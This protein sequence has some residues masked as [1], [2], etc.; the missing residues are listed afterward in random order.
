[1]KPRHILLLLFLAFT[2]TSAQELPETF[3]LR[4]VNGQNYVS[5]VKAQSGGTCW[6][7]GTMASVESNLMVTGVWLD[8]GESGEP[9]LAEYHLDWWNG[10]NKFYN[11]DII[12]P[13]STELQVHQGGDYLVSTAYFSRGDGAVRDIDGQSYY[14][15]PEFASDSYH[16]YYIRDVEWYDIGENLERIILLKRKIMEYGAVATVILAGITAS[17]Y[18][19]YQPPED[20]RPP[21]HSVTIIGW[22]DK[23][24]T[25]APLPGAWLVKNS[26]GS[27][28][29]EDGYFWISYYDKHVGHYPEMGA[30]SF[31]NVEPMQ[32]DHVYFH[33]YHGWRNTKTD[34]EAVVNAFDAVASVGGSESMEAVSFYTAADNVDYT[35]KIYGGVSEGELTDE[36][37]SQIGFIEFT[38]FHT[39]DLT[40]P[41]ELKEGDRFY[42]YLQLSDGGYA[43]DQTS[44]VPL[45]LS[46]KYNNLVRSKASRGE[47]FYREGGEWLDLIDLDTTANFCIKALSKLDYD[48]DGIN[49]ILDNCPEE[50][51]PGQADRDGDFIGDLCDEC[52]DDPFNDIDGDGICGDGDNCPEY[53]NP[54]Q[55]DND[56]DGIGDDCDNCPSLY[57]PGQEDSDGD[58]DGDA[59][60]LCPNDPLNDIDADGFCGDVDNC[61]DEYNPEQSDVN[62]N[63]IGD[64]CEPH[65]VVYTDP[66]ANMNDVKK[67]SQFL[68][69]FDNVID[70]D[71]LMNTTASIA[72][73]SSGLHGGLRQFDMGQREIFIEPD[74][75]FNAGE[76]VEV[77]IATDLGVIRSSYSY[78]FRIACALSSGRFD[79]PYD[80]YKVGDGPLGID[81]GDFNGDGL[82]DLATAN[83]YDDNITVYFN[84]GAGGFA[85]KADYPTGNGAIDV[86]AF[87]LDNDFDLD[88]V[89]ANQ[90]ANNVTVL[91]NDGSGIFTNT[92]D[93]TVKNMPTGVFVSDVDGD[94]FAD[95]LTADISSDLGYVTVL[96]ND[97]AGQFGERSDFLL[98]SKSAGV[99]TGD[100]DN[101]GDFDMASADLNSNS[102]SVFKNNRRG[103]FSARNNYPA[104]N[105]PY[106][107]SCGDIDRDFDLDLVATNQIGNTVTVLFNDG[108]AGFDSAATYNTPQS[109]SGVELG[110]IDGDND[111]DIVTVNR[112]AGSVSIFYNNGEGLF[113]ISSDYDIGG[114]PYALAIADFNGD[115]ILDIAA[116]DRDNSNI[117]IL[118]QRVS[119][120]LAE[121]EDILPTE[122]KLDQNYPNPFNPE[123]EINFALPRSEQTSLEIYNILGQKVITLIDEHLP[124]GIHSVRW[125][126]LDLNGNPVSSGVY[127]YRFE[128]GEFNG[129]RKMILLK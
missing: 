99:V 6:T 107:I 31:H 51:N 125:N 20:E 105:Y 28:W 2:V 34:C 69:A 1:M 33:D 56:G 95:I 47:S 39:I 102:I 4:N 94:G 65:H 23:K 113:G 80:Q 119:T 84:D 38:G 67:D 68:F 86:M 122:Y 85:G 100:F 3:D 78:Q 13:D 17:D 124:A 54:F 91:R 53:A 76:L 81:A 82:I 29:G 41:V 118:Y 52:P 73:H 32:Y 70:D 57:N 66:E 117:I 112:T 71:A 25:P 26:W 74:N 98:S 22:D 7:H 96:I 101:D 18:T 115:D 27:T 49:D 97:R 40:Q 88:L 109:P 58:L 123:T 16:Y 116:A 45:L 127:F 63:G 35:L 108:F 11:G 128:S 93:Y 43:Y 79:P 64:V 111:L 59:C 14:D 103:G 89:A 114:S 121:F 48:A 24:E 110:D 5:S 77:T 87:D 126:G 104:G 15:P 61:P 75:S 10:F 90:A 106:N 60:D 9:N 30:V 19:H 50:N 62:D 8:H 92:G 120:D 72:G 12:P 37:H 55:A 129:S 42:V 44:E 46:A 36:L 83:Y 21:N